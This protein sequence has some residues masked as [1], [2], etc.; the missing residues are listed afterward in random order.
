MYSVSSATYQL[1]A[2]V[3]RVFPARARARGRTFL[4]SFHAAPPSPFVAEFSRAFFFVFAHL[5]T[6]RIK[7]PV[8]SPRSTRPELRRTQ[9][10]HERSRQTATPRNKAA[11]ASTLLNPGHPRRRREERRRRSSALV[12]EHIPGPQGSKKSTANR[13]SRYS[14]NVG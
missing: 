1:H 6:A 8:F 10:G 12:R 3:K 13:P 4:T 5:S 11:T 7:I 2:V 9:S 14:R